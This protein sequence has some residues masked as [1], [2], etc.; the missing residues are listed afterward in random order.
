MGL[1][2]LMTGVGWLSKVNKFADKAQVGKKLGKK[3]QEK[4]TDKLREKTIDKVKT[5]I[6]DA[7]DKVRVGKKAGKKIKKKVGET[8]KKVAKKKGRSQVEKDNLKMAKEAPKRNKMDSVSGGDS[9][10]QGL[11]G[12]TGLGLHET[13]WNYEPVDPMEYMAGM[14]MPEFEQDSEGDDLRKSA[15]SGILNG[16]GL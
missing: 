6:R 10:E 12:L 13:D 5:P 14:T 16:L 3:L 15:V 1:L 7:V 2:G 9:F 4:T 8:V 11:M